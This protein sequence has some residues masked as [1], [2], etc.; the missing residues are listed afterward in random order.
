MLGFEADAG[1]GDL[2][3][4][5]DD[6]SPNTYS[7]FD[8]NWDAHVRARA[9]YVYNTTLFYVAGGLALA[10]VDVDDVDPNYGE[11]NSAHL[12]WTFGAG[13]EQRITEHLTARVEYLYDNYGSESYAIE[14]A[15]SGSYQADVELKTHSARIGLAYSF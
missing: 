14:E 15:G 8:V 6:S 5:A 7:A 4:G 9:G 10:E 2:S 12:G 11:D 1:F 3:E 13:I